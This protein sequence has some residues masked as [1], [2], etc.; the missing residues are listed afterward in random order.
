VAGTRHHPQGMGETYKVMAITRAN[1][2]PPAP[3][4]IDFSKLQ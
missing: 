4:D 2:K 1:A 3:F